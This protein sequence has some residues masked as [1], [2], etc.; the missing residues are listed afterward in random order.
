MKKQFAFDV[1]GTLVNKQMQILP[2]AAEFIGKIIDSINNV[3]I[4]ITSGAS[5]HEVEL[6]IKLINQNLGE[7][8]FTPKIIAHGGAY[9]Q[10]DEKTKV[11]N[12]LEPNELEELL[13]IVYN[14]DPH[15][16]ICFRTKEV[17]FYADKNLPENII[18]T[19]RS[20]PKSFNAVN[21]QKSLEFRDVKINSREIFGLEIIS[22]KNPTI[23]K[24]LKERYEKEGFIVS[25]GTCIEINKVGKVNALLK[26]YDDLKNVIYF[27]DGYND[28]PCF[29][30]CGVSFGIGNNYEAIKYATHKI[31]TYYEAIE[32]FFEDDLSL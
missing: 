7:E 26:V 23:Y 27:G 31:K 17:N 22:A 9:I 30:E 19:M 28:I 13:R 2:G 21:N 10:I 20:L 4:V 6:A 12:P 18:K 25:F 29:R 3:E 1:D 8:K 11:E 15:C 16:A 32:K 24:M 14:I 5:L